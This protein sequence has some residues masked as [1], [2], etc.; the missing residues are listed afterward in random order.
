MTRDIFNSG[1][2]AIQNIEHA[3]SFMPQDILAVANSAWLGVSITCMSVLNK[4]QKNLTP[5]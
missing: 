2:T 3:H 4:V 5:E 1:I